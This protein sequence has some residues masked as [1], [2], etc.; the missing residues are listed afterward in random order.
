MS[1]GTVSS[2]FAFRF[3]IVE[4]IEMDTYMK[5]KRRTQYLFDS[6]TVDIITP[7]PYTFI[8]HQHTCCTALLQCRNQIKQKTNI[9]STRIIFCSIN[10]FVSFVLRP[11]L[12]VNLPFDFAK[13]KD[14]I[15][16][17]AC[18]SLFC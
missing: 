1:G 11:S 12:T 15:Y 5:K 7:Y 17:H 14:K 3:H 6:K 18:T 13:W 9:P 8:L 2:F 16:K 10:I 4:S